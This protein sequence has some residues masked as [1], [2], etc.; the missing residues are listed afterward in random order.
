VAAIRPAAVS[1]SGSNDVS[2]PVVVWRTDGVGSGI[3]SLVVHEGR[4][5]V[6]DR[7]V[8]ACLDA[9]SGV[10]LSKT[11]LSPSEATFYASPV[12]ADGKLFAVSRESGIYVLSTEPKFVQ[13]AN[14]RLDD[15]VFNATPAIHD[16]ELLLRS[17]KFLYCIGEHNRP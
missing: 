17:N 12:V 13:L 14:N 15:S 4:V 2:Q 11:R 10:I 5:Y 16:R 6:V 9:G 1:P 3:A 8:A 7:G